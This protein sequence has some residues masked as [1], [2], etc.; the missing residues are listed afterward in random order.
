MEYYT[1]WSI[2]IPIYLKPFGVNLW[3]LKYR[4]FDLK[5]IIVYQSMG[6]KDIGNRKLEFVT[7][8]FFLWKMIFLRM[9]KYE[10]K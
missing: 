6:C 9:E 2:L 5:E 8:T 1:N 7:K 3:N 10:V 4:L